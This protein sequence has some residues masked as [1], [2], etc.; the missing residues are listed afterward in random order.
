MNLPASAVEFLDAF[1]GAFDPAVWRGRLPWVHCYTFSKCETPQG[2]CA[3]A[4]PARADTLA[5]TA[6]TSPLL[7][8]QPFWR[9]FCARILS[10]TGEGGGAAGAPPL[11]RWLWHPAPS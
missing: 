3:A 9:P 11:P 1:H 8:P 6:S 7:P 10:G 4:G 2:A 5:S